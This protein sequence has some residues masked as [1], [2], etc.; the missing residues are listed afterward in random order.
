MASQ[1]HKHRLLQRR[2]ELQEAIRPL[3]VLEEELQEV[4]R[5]LRTYDA[6]EPERDRGGPEDR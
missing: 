5:L 1:V 6:Q 3:L 4:E 2:K